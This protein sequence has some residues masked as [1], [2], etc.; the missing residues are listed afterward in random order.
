MNFKMWARGLLAAVINA[1]V[2]SLSAIFADPSHFNLFEQAG[3]IAIGKVALVA[4]ISGALIYLK[5]HPL[6]SQD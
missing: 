2:T 1:A 5:T 3:V 6:P 4:A